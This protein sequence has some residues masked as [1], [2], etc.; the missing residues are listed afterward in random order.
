MATVG[1]CCPARGRH[2]TAGSLQVGILG[3]PQGRV[4]V[5]HSSVL[6]VH[7]FRV[8]VSTDWSVAGQ[9]SSVIAAGS[10]IAHLVLLLFWARS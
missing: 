9:G 2:Q 4:S 5:E 3:E 1:G 7:P 6:Q 10:G 8:M